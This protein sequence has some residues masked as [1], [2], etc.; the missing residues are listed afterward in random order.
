MP[1]FQLSGLDHEQ[2]HHLFALSDE[3]LQAI[4]AERHV[5][6]A[7][8]GFPCRVSLQDA[9]IGEEL[10]LLP[11]WHQSEMS[12]YRASGPIFIRRSASRCVLEAGI[13]PAYVTRR[14]MSLRAYDAAHMM[15]DASVCDGPSVSNELDRMFANEDVAYIHLHNAKRGCFS[16]VAN[17]I[18]A[19]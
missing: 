8:F 2:F 7:S 1:C 13:V 17:R 11:Y 5:A 12:P 6:T 15:V 4:N 16:C 18:Q 14:L 10:L 3:K 19:A 9:E